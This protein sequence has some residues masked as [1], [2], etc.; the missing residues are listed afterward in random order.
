MRLAESEFEFHRHLTLRAFLIGSAR[1]VT[2]RLQWQ[3]FATPATVKAVARTLLAFQPLGK[4]PAHVY[5]Q[6]TA[7]LG[8][9]LSLLFEN[10]IL[11]A[12]PAETRSFMSEPLAS[13]GARDGRLEQDLDRI[14][15]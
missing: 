5:M 15:T 14:R 9:I 10:W 7:V 11:G 4:M 12:Q 6:L 13:S 1:S 8:L 3:T 2:G